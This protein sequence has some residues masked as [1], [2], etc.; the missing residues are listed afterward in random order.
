MTQ[1]VSS[2]PR[3][4]LPSP[5]GLMFPLAA[6]LAL[7]LLGFL[8]KTDPAISAWDTAFLLGLHHYAT[9]ELNRAVAA[10]SN[11]GTHLGVLPASI[12]FT[13][14]ALG[15]RRWSTAAY[16]TLVM[17]GS[18]VL[19]LTTKLLWQRPRPGLWEGVPFHGD[20]S[21]PSGHATYSM[22]FVS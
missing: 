7:I 18:A 16:L 17:A 15:Q 11:L 13:V 12:V 19:N 3:L 5:F 2:T 1:S 21:F 14:L 9:P 4:F 6:L 22:T 10:V 8:V 20:F